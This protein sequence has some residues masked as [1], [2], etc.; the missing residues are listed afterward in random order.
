MTGRIVLVGTP[1]GNLGDLSS[2]AVAALRDADAVF[3]EDT[4]RTRKL[5][6]ASS[7]PA[8]KLYALHQHN[9]EA[10]SRHA[11]SMAES[12]AQIAVVSDAGMPG[13]SDPGSVLVR[14]AAE[15]GVALEIV[16]GPSALVVALVASG[17]PTDRF[18]FEGFLPR[19]GRERAER[20][21]QISAETRTVVLYE[22]PHRARKTLADL[23]GACGADRQVAVARELTKIHEEIRRGTLGEASRWVQ[24]SEPR[25]E[26]AIVVAG[27]PPAGEPTD[28][29]ILSA[30]RE[31]FDAG[32][33]KRVAVDEVAGALGLSRRR[34]YQLALDATAS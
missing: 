2:R 10:A 33:T 15:A 19:Q 23:A 18:C 1:I 4:R 5:L 31:R 7:I 27:A 6:S 25:G 20:L 26:W 22:A 16:P 12:G 14:I 21:R 8:P 29:D 24:E 28:E 11:L 17:L 32:A 3:C 13:I 30:L 34:V 9:E